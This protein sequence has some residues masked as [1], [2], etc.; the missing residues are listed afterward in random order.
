[1]MKDIILFSEI[2]HTRNLGALP[3]SRARLLGCG[4]LGLLDNVLRAIRVLRLCDPRNSAMM[5]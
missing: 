5:G 2:C 4:P 3:A 1:M